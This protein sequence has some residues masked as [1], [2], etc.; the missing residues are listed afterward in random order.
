MMEFNL[1]KIF[2]HLFLTFLFTINDAFCNLILSKTNEDGTCPNNGLYYVKNNYFGKTL[3]CQYTYMQNNCHDLRSEISCTSG[4]R[5]KTVG[6]C[7]GCLDSCRGMISYCCTGKYCMCEKE[8]EEI[9]KCGDFCSRKV[10]CRN[11]YLPCSVW[12]ECPKVGQICYDNFYINNPPPL[13]KALNGVYSTEPILIIFNENIAIESMIISTNGCYDDGFGEY[14]SWKIELLSNFTIAKISYYNASNCNENFKI[15]TINISRGNEVSI[16]SNKN[17]LRFYNDKISCITN[18]QCLNGTCKEKSCL[19]I[20]N[21]NNDINNNS[22]VEKNYNTNGCSK[23]NIF[24]T[25]ILM[26]IIIIIYIYLF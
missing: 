7:D 16:F 13:R 22:V 19:Q 8:C 9:I 3:C 2:Y 11:P 17:R 23:R 5:S 12:C 6:D 21:N 1:E 15:N 10:D 14:P 18:Q 20:S 4:G 24:I 25:N 26:P